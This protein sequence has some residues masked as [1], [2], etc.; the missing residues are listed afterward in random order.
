MI[1]VTRRLW[2]SWEDDAVIRDTATG[3]FLDADKVHHVNFTGEHFSIAGP[4]I[5]PR[6]PQGQLVVLGA[7]TLGVTDR[8]DI[9]LITAPGPEAV[10]ARARQARADGAPLV[11]ADLTGDPD[12]LLALIDRLGDI[13]DGVRL[14]LTD[15]GDF[16]RLAAALG[17]APVTG[18]TLRDTLGLPRPANQFVTAV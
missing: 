3:R 16:P 14:H 8:L 9:A 2:D 18:P 13:V 12:E 11:F 10:D 5:T 1:D 15:L 17:R 4:L 7:D 6:P